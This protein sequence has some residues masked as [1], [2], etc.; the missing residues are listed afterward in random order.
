MLAQSSAIFYISIEG[1]MG[2]SNKMLYL[3][4][5][6]QFYVTN[7]VSKH[8]NETLPSPAKLVENIKHCELL[9]G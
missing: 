5:L 1:L 2:V 4:P 6:E 7:Y 9:Y 8:C 3:F